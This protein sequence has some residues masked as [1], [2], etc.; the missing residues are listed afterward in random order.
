MAELTVA[1]AQ[2]DFLVGGVEINAKKIVAAIARARDE[3]GADLVCFPELALTGYPP[4]DLL[5]RPGL[6]KKIEAVLPEIVQAAANINVIFGMPRRDNDVL[7]NS[8]IWIRDRQIVGYYDK[9]EL[10]N[11][12]VF[13]EKR[14]FTCGTNAMV[15]NVKNIPVG[16]TICEDVW[17]AQPTRQAVQAG[18][19][20]VININASPFHLGKIQDREDVVVERALENACPIV[21]L[22]LVGCQ[23]ELVFDG[24]SFVVD[25]D[26]RII[27]RC[28]AFGETIELARF[29]VDSTTSRLVPKT[30]TLNRYPDRETSAYQALVFGVR[31]YIQKNGFNGAVL[32]LS[33]GIDSAL[34]LCIAVDALGAKNVEAV[35]LPSRYTAQMSL[36]D[37]QKLA[38]NLG[39]N[40]RVMSIEPAFSVF[41]DT[42][43]NEFTGLAPDVTEENIQARCRGVILMAISNKTGKMVLTTGNKSELAT[44]Y[45]TLYGDMAGGYNVL[46]DVPKML[47]YQL[48][49]YRNRISPVV[50]RRIIDR[51]PTAELRFNQTDQDSLP[52]YPVLDAIIE[53]YVE[54]DVSLEQMI[55]DGFDA[56]TVR[57]V[58]RMLDRNEYKRRQ[59]PPGVRITPRAF[60]KDRRYP[61]TSGYKE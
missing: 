42:L 12:S 26:G 10:P 58:I 60:G 57:K 39:V 53:R 16:V 1:M 32:G 11:Y 4:E 3:L 14:Y 13:D 36:D 19:Q 30:L 56:E 27:Q 55:A 6:Y 59:G 48:S 41:L 33:G 9:H 52:P 28:I 17:F 38:E 23:D 44:G 45:S 47:V 31:D 43:A 29:N 20:V 18:A 7:F 15:V 25:G 50:P 54:Q 51:A 34:T 8:A 2:L 40:Y 21:Y 46:K 24:A 35:M 49:E 22:N 5:W 61:I 37:A